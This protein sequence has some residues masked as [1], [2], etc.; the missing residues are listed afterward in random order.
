MLN[1]YCFL[2][3]YIFLAFGILHCSF[4]QKPTEFYV[5]KEYPAQNSVLNVPIRMSVQT[6]QK[7]INEELK[8]LIYAAN[9][10]PGMGGTRLSIKVWKLRDITFEGKGNQLLTYAPLKVWVQ[11]KI[12]VNVLGVQL[13]KNIEQVLKLQVNINTTMGLRKNWRLH[14]TS[15]LTSYQWIEKPSLNLGLIKIDVS[16]MIDQYIEQEK[17]T[18]LRQ[19]DQQIQQHLDFKKQ[20]QEAWHTFQSPFATSEWGEEKTWLTLEP[21]NLVLTD[22]SFQNKELVV[23]AGVEAKAHAQL[24]KTPNPT[25]PKPLP[26]LHQVP[27]VAD[28]V[29]MHIQG[30][31]SKELAIEKAKEVF[32]KETYEFRNGKYKIDIKDLSIYG[33]G[34]KMV[35]QLDLEGSVEGRVYLTGIPVYNAKTDQLEVTE[36]DYVMNA[37]ADISKFIRWLF[38][39]KIKKQ[40]K[41]S[42]EE[43]IHAQIQAIRKDIE[44]NLHNY[45]INN[46]SVLNGEL[47]DFY[48]DKIYMTKDTVFARVM[49]TGNFSI[50]LTKL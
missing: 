34:E 22:L 5:E 50:E 2:L 28:K 4:A 9:D 1:R 47:K 20:I 12:N 8:S 44:K 41:K 48:F 14:T 25:S 49:L 21:K 45:P 38:A 6:L 18:L 36:F 16:S 32:T 43:S 7:E 30:K 3:I 40:L 26:A 33:S 23:H 17:S 27:E 24:S 42:M 13:A 37:R 31:I 10:L 46:N 19:F 39:K 29:E 35:I 15:F 11:G